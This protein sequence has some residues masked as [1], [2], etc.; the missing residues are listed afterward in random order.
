MQNPAQKKA[1]NNVVSTRLTISHIK[2]FYSAKD[3][4]SH[5]NGIRIAAQAVIIHNSTHKSANKQR[6]AKSMVTK[7]LMASKGSRLLKA[8]HGFVRAN[9]NVGSRDI[10]VTFRD[11]FTFDV[12]RKRQ[13]K[14]L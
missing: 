6:R 9:V 3:F 13:S 4:G 2:Q 10:L 11:I 12:R 7:I 5:V 1:R 14:I 8:W